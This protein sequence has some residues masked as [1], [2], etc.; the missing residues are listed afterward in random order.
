MDKFDWMDNIADRM[1]GYGES[2]PDGLW[3]AVTSGYAR[4]RRRRAAAWTAAGSVF[5]AAAVVLTVWLWRPVSPVVVPVSDTVLADVVSVNGADAAVLHDEVPAVVS[6]D[7]YVPA[8]LPSQQDG[9]HAALPAQTGQRASLLGIM[10][11][12]SIAPSSTTPTRGGD[13]EAGRPEVSNDAALPAQQEQRA[14]ALEEMSREGIAPTSTTPAHSGDAE[15]G[16]QTEETVKPEA[17][18]F[19]GAT[20][21]I[22]R[23][24]RRPLRLEGGLSTGGYIAQNI[25]TT[26]TSVGIPSVPGRR[27]TAPSLTKAS[28]SGS[29]ESPLSLLSR[30]RTSTTDATHSQSARLSATVRLY[31]TDRW[32]VES[33]LVRTQLQSVYSTTAGSNVTRT[34]RTLTYLGVP[35]FV[36]YDFLEWKGLRLYAVGGPMFEVCT[37]RRSETYSYATGSSSKP[38]DSDSDNSPYEDRKWSLN[39]GAGAQYRLFGS[40]S[41]FVQPGIAWYIP[42]NSTLESWY[43]E[44]PFSPSLTLGLRFSW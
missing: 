29:S 40:C 42:D 31:L 18:A 24:T 32:A 7:V 33:G 11:Q 23:R 21:V 13:A 37:S 1:D 28:G 25:S 3:D 4:L 12:G 27:A 36:G 19:D 2:A 9:S 41:A 26:S 22:G 34:E 20:A 39:L 6:E 43:T 38:V 30:N 16:R 10:S 17:K 5:A 14:S 44:R 35:V 15:A 8:A